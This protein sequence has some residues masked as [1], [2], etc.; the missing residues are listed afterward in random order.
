[1]TSEITGPLRLDLVAESWIGQPH[2]AAGVERL[3]SAR[4]AEARHTETDR[5]LFQA[6]RLSC[7]LLPVFSER[8]I[9]PEGEGGI[10][11]AVEAR[12]VRH[13]EKPAD[14]A[15]AGR[16]VAFSLRPAPPETIARELYRLRTL[17]AG[18]RGETQE[19]LE[20]IA[21]VWIEELSC[22]PGDIV[23]TTLREWPRRVNGKWWPTWHEL[24][25]VLDARA[26]YR[27]SIAASLGLPADPLPRAAK[28]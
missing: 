13:P 26:S 4:L 21:A 20:M 2:G 5:N 11:M 16:L 25:R 6:L 23:A 10:D 17:T 18:K 14:E 7:R 19:D 8:T 24:S 28:G 3:P 27:R 1:M 15:M 12:L 22:Y 9:Y